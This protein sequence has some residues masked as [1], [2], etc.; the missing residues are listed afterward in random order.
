[1]NTDNK[2]PAMKLESY[3]FMSV[4]LLFEFSLFINMEYN[5]NRFSNVTTV[6]VLSGYVQHV[7][8]CIYII[9]LEF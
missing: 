3:L 7:C 9:S 6:L 8:V 2:A 5:I 1:M 4:W